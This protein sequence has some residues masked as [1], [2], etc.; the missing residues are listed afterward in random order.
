M[1]S[2]ERYI[3]ECSKRSPNFALIYKIAAVS[4]E[5]AAVSR[6]HLGASRA[7][8][9]L[10]KERT[11]CDGCTCPEEKDETVLMTAITEIMFVI[12]MMMLI[13]TIEIIMIIYLW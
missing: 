4:P 3:F 10:G 5:R 6:V 7:A 8:E 1:V 13:I 11:V 12:I 2:P 9:R